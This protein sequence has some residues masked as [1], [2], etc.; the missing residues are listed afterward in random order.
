MNVTKTKL[1]SSQKHVLKL[2]SRDRKADGWTIISSMLY[3]PLSASIPAELAT[4]EPVGDAG[5]AKLTTEG[6]SLLD[7]LEWL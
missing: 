6:Q 2:I 4:F 5:R 7:A 1:D 3:R